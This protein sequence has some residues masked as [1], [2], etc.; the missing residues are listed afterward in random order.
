MSGKDTYEEAVKEI[1]HQNENFLVDNFENSEN[2]DWEGFIQENYVEKTC[3]N[4]SQSKEVSA[5]EPAKKRMKM[6]YDS[7][8]DFDVIVVKTLQQIDKAKNPKKSDTTDAKNICEECQKEGCRLYCIG[9]CYKN[10]LE[11]KLKCIKD[12]IEALRKR[13]EM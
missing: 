3:Q 13:V 8:L 5:M 11:Y 7:N 6:T 2:E 10:I 12:N 1:L 9:I 4:Q